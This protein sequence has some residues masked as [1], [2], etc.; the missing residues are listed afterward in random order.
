MKK[1][2]QYPEKMQATENVGEESAIS[3][4][5]EKTL[6]CSTRPFV[7]FEDFPWNPLH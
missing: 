7:K 2:K 6:I 5:L 4:D 1:T 3:S